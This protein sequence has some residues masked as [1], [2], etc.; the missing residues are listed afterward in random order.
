MK[1]IKGKN[2]MSQKDIAQPKAKWVY[3]KS[4]NL[5]K[6]KYD[7]K[8]RLLSILYINAKQ[9]QYN[10]VKVPGRIYFGLINSTSKGTYFNDKI[11]N[12]FSF[13]IGAY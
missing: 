4:T 10:Y 1:S 6:V 5:W 7:P 9:K 13:Y 2:P 3:V 8:E 12:I 11:K